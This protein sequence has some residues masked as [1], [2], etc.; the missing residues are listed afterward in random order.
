MLWFT[1]ACGPSAP[2]P[3]PGP[4]VEPGAYSFFEGALP[5]CATTGEPRIVRLERRTPVRATVVTRSGRY[6]RVEHDGSLGWIATEDADDTRIITALQSDEP[7][8]SCLQAALTPFGSQRWLARTASWISI[9]DLTTSR[10][11]RLSP[12]TGGLSDCRVHDGGASVV[13]QG[14]SGPVRLDASGVVLSGNYEPVW[15][16]ELYPD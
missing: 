9:V 2:P 11:R 15:A 6:L 10:V 13:C 7:G 1:L 16:K 12:A 5:G 14:S 4:M 3:P 8:T